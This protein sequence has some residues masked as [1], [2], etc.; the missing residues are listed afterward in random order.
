MKA[1]SSFALGSGKIYQEPGTM[2]GTLNNHR[3]A[4]VSHTAITVIRY[5]KQDYIE[6]NTASVQDCCPETRYAGV[7]WINIEGQLD[8]D[9]LTQLGQYYDLHPLALEDVINIGQRPKWEPYAE[10]DFMVMFMLAPEEHLK[11]HQVSMFLGKDF[12][13]TLQDTP[14]P[15]L[16]PIR[17]HLRKR[18][19]I[20][21]EKGADY[22]C[23]TICDT[24]IDQLFPI[25]E[26]MGEQL[27]VMELNLLQAPDS[28]IPVKIHQ[29][30]RDLLLIGRLAWAEREVVNSLQREE[31]HLIEHETA[32]YLR[33]A[34]DHVAQ[35]IDIIETYRDITTGIL[36]SYLSSISNQTNSIMKMLTIIATVFIPLTFIVG[37]YGMN[38]NTAVSPYNMPE[39]NMRYGYITVW[40]V[41][42]LIVSGMFIAFRRKKWL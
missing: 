22:L 26:Q 21:R 7:T 36:D 25:L 40:I 31:S 17:E 1:N 5:N 42:L 34:Y 30:K 2:P 14:N 29:I 24:L 20:L 13:L 12:V 33:D 16:Q 28:D 4:I 3:K 23:Y 8:A 19:G 6:S 15:L 41:M 11:A 18:T 38:F 32:I 27:D 9:L 37:L 10:N 35:I 39:L